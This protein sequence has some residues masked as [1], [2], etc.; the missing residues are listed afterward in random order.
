MHAP[1]RIVLALALGA[2]VGCNRGPTKTDL[3]PEEKHILKLASLYGDFRAKTGRPPKTIE[4][5]KGFA[6]KMS[7]QDLASRGLDDLD[8]AFVSQRDNQPYK[9]APPQPP[10]RGG[11]PIPGI[12][13][14]EQTGVD[15]KHMVANGM[16]GAFEMDEADLR[17]VVP[18][19]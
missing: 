9:L 6:R 10:Q 5:L 11:P 8:K 4:E 12:I 7:K 16:G 1:R 14:Y 2:L 3:A 18:N 15:G 13:F 17:Q 19:P